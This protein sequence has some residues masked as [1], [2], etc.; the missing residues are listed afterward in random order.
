MGSLHHEEKLDLYMEDISDFLRDHLTVDM[1]FLLE[2]IAETNY[3]EKVGEAI[4]RIVDQRALQRITID[5][6]RHIMAWTTICKNRTGVNSVISIDISQPITIHDE[7]HLK[8][9]EADYLNVESVEINLH[10]SFE[11]IVPISNAFMAELL[12]IG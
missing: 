5:N 4:A 8:C 1:N 3:N 7:Q 2:L 9:F 10:S 11:K 12:K 6:I